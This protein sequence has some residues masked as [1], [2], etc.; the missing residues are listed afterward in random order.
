MNDEQGY[1]NTWTLVATP[2]IEWY[3]HSSFLGHAFSYLFS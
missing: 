2:A 1:A 3:R